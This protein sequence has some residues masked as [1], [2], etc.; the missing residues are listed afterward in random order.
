MRIRL[1]TISAAFAIG[2]AALSSSTA[3]AQYYY[4]PCSSPF[5]LAWP[6][7]VAGVVLGTA[8]N[9]ATAPIWLLAG[10]PPP[11]PYG[12]Y[13]PPPPYY[14]PPGITRRRIIMRHAKSAPIRQAA[15]VVGS[16]AKI[17]TQP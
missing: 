4:P 6:F 8:V 3:N 1:V 11:F 14:R 7:C 5:P 9:I 17:A 12:Y 16:L 10:A 13:R 15:F 2:L